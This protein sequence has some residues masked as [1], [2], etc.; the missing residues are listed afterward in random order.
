[1][2]WNNLT[3]GLIVATV[4]GAS[5]LALSTAQADSG[6]GERAEFAPRQMHEMIRPDPLP[7]QERGREPKAEPSSRPS[8]APKK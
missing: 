2:N 8:D 1:M 4:A 5:L 3:K 7:G 6:A